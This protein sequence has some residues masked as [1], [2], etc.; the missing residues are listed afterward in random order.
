MVML[1][2]PKVPIDLHLAAKINPRLALHPIPLSSIPADPSV[3]RGKKDD[4]VL[5]DSSP[6]NGIQDLSHMIVH[7]FHH[8]DIAG[9]ERIP[10]TAHIFPNGRTNVSGVGSM[11]GEV[12]EKR[13][14]S[15][16]L[17]ERATSIG[18]E[19]VDI[20]SILPFPVLFDRIEEGWLRI[21]WNKRL[22]DIGVF[23]DFGYT[24]IRRHRVRV[25]C[26]ERS[27]PLMSVTES[28]EAE[29]LCHPF[30]NGMALSEHTGGVAGLTE[31][32]SNRLFVGT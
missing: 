6:A 3:V 27:M 15:V 21:H 9:G 8:R 20:G 26:T 16:F 30:S 28:I 18:G 29:M 32:L 31:S 4:R 23:M 24:L 11:E 19:I 22:A 13:L 1:P 10:T 12:E 2:L 7:P 17:D 5:I 25:I 14:P